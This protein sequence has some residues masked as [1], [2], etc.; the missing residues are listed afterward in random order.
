MEEKTSKPAKQGA[1][2]NKTGLI[3]AIVVAVVV[4]IAVVV[5]IIIMTGKKDDGQANDGNN[6][7]SSNTEVGTM[8]I[9]DK[10]YGFVTIPNNWKKVENEEDGLQYSDPKK[11]YFVSMLV[12][13]VDEEL[14]AELWAEG[15]KVVF[16]QS[17]VENVETETKNIPGV[18]DAVVVTGHFGSPYN[19]WLAAWIVDTPDGK[20]H[21]VAVE[22]PDKNNDIFSVP[23]T[24][25]YTK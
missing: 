23:E 17:G 7:G 25:K 18:G 1:A 21:Y 24:F 5:A 14:N 3:A 10:D 22:G 9:G 2:N 20:V 6:G 4:V 15:V 11:E 16:A 13:D 12:E 19:R 8:E